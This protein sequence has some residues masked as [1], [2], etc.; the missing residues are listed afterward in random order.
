MVLCNLSLAL[1]DRLIKE[2]GMSLLLITHDLGIVAD[3]CDTVAVMYAGRVVEQGTLEDIFDHTMHPYTEG[4]FNS[5]PNI[6][7]RTERLKPIKGL[8]PDPTN[9]PDGCAFASR[10]EYA[11]ERCMQQRPVL[12][13][14][15]QTHKCACLRYEEPDFHIERGKIN[16]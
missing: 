9:L 6:N 1:I 5:L 2:K 14:V 13:A 3:V 11:C 10:C 8:M 4:L 7:Q 12:E 16:G 15:S